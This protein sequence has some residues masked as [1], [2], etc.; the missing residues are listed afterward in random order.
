MILFIPALAGC[1]GDLNIGGLGAVEPTDYLRDDQY[2]NWVIEVDYV[3]GFRPSPSALSLLKARMAELVH[4]DNIDIVVDDALP[5]T[6]RNWNIPA[7]LD[8]KRDH[9]DFTTT[10]D[11]IVTWVA[12]LDGQ[13][14]SDGGGNVLGVALSDHETVGILA[15]DIED[16]G[17]LL[18]SDL[19]VE[20][21]VIIHELGHI[22]G[23]VDNGLE[24]QT[25]HSDGGAHSNSRSSVMWA[26][27]ET[28]S[29]INQ[30]NGS[31][32]TTFD[33][34]DKRDVACAGGKGTC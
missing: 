20:K 5:A 29:G 19:D 4:K 24:M 14:P 12:Y 1:F 15:E 21:T 33:A 28:A 13:W 9:Q 18:I 25:A 11:R 3:E 31:P 8:L 10:G 2:T 34:N 16:S 30:L 23:L 17:F 32:P 7:L 22:L 27:V 6:G 26:G